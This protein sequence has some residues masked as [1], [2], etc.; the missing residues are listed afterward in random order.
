MFNVEVLYNS[1]TCHTKDLGVEIPLNRRP[2]A[3]LAP[4]RLNNVQLL[5]HSGSV[6]G[7]NLAKTTDVAI[8]GVGVGTGCI[9]DDCG[10]N[11]MTKIVVDI[12]VFVVVIFVIDDN[13][14]ND[15]GD[16]V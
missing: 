14:N 1:T 12:V 16:A 4:E 15:F 11:Y 5:Y 13:N 2:R 3:I 10:V 6:Q 8:G 9:C 7:I